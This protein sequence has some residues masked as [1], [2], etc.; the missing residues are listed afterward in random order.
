MRKN[1]TLFQNVVHVPKSICSYK[2]PIPDHHILKIASLSFRLEI[3]KILF[4]VGYCDLNDSYSSAFNRSFTESLL[5]H[6]GT[7]EGIAVKQ[8]RTVQKKKRRIMQRN[9]CSSINKSFRENAAINFLASN[10]SFS[11]YQR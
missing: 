6:C 10:E 3:M 4:L 8:T 9:I 1:D 5:K 7:S 2:S 11:G